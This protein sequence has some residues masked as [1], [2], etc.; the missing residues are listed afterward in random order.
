MTGAA[1]S[2]IENSRPPKLRFMLLIKILFIATQRGGG[3]IAASIAIAIRDGIASRARPISGEPSATSGNAQAQSSDERPAARA[4]M[5]R[6]PN[7][8]ATASFARV[9]LCV[10]IAYNDASLRLMQ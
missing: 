5:R 8:S 9:R 4:A 10:R 6:R 1:N 7:A 2:N 3:R